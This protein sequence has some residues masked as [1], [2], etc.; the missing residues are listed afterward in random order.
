LIPLLYL[1]AARLYRGHASERPVL[2]VAHAGLAVMLVTSI[3]AAFRGFVLHADE[4][5][6]LQLSLFFAEAAVFY[7]LEAFWRRHAYS[8]YATTAAASAAVWQLLKYCNVAEEYYILTFAVVGLALLVVYRFA[9]LEKTGVGGMAGAASQ[10]GNALVSLAFVA[11]AFL[12]LS[13][14]A[15]QTA[16]R[17]V[18]VSLLLTLAAIALAAVVLVRQEGWRRWYVAAAITHAGLCVLVLAVLSKL[19][20]ASD[21]KSSPLWRGCCCWGRGISAGIASRKGITTWSASPCSSAACWW[22]CR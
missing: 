17:G 21:W 4:T 15:Q 16:E 20:W 12:T 7:G 13:E 18:L 11:G 22:R 14:L 19:T 2:W 8:V 1:G 5:L 3:G 9:V 10:C 6:N